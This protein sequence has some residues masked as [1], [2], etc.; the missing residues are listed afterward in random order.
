MNKINIG[1]E[2][3][4]INF[5]R[6]AMIEFEKLT[7]QKLLSGSKNWFESAESW[8]AL[9]Y[10]GLKWGLYNPNKGQEPKPPFT[11]FQVNDWIEQRIES[12]QDM[13]A[14]FNNSFPKEKKSEVNQKDISRGTTSTESV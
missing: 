10:S 6:N 11:L 2:E 1:G 5:G 7:G 12:L 9:M 4:P 8:T 3:R 13:W 14:I